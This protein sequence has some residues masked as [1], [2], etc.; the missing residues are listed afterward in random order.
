MILDHPNLFG[1][2]QIDLLG[3]K[4]IW[5]GPNHFGQVQIWLLWTNVYNLDPTK[6]KWT[7]PKL[8]VLNQ[9]DL[10]IQNYFGPIEGQGKKLQKLWILPNNFQMEFL[11]LDQR[12]YWVYRRQQAII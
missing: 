8:L 7:G 2:L 1:Q 6:R 9:N 4:P 10:T 11:I 3:S 12:D 5:S